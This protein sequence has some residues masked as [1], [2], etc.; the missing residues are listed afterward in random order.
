MPP[1]IPAVSISMSLP[2]MEYPWDREHRL[3][4]LRP[5]QVYR[6]QLDTSSMASAGD[7]VFNCGGAMVSTNSR[8]GTRPRVGTIERIEARGSH[9]QLAPRGP[10]GAFDG[11][12]PD[13]LLYA[14][15]SVD[16]IPSHFAPDQPFAYF[17]PRVQMAQAIGGE[18]DRLGRAQFGLARVPGESDELYRARLMHVWGGQVYGQTVPEPPEV[19]PPV[20][21]RKTA[22][23]RVLEPDL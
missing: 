3:D 14:D 19:I 22:W 17:T 9:A 8:G 15:V 10:S 20:R 21:P 23:E 11:Y 7:V 2:A 6:Y 5:R 18:L 16:A 4:G 1:P 13:V 12:A